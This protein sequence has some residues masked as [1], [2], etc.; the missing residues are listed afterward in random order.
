[1][2]GKMKYIKY[3]ETFEEYEDWMK[4]ESNTEE[5]FESEEKICVDGLILSHTNKSFEE[6]IAEGDDE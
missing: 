6:S 5:V 4:N 2:G 3:F 1:M